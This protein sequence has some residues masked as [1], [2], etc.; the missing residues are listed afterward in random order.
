MSVVASNLTS[1]STLTSAS[2]Y[3]SSSISPVANA[4]ILVSVESLFSTGTPNTPTVTGTSMTWVQ[5]NTEFDGSHLRVTVFRSLSAAPGSGAL[6]IDFSAQAQHDV[7]IS[8]DQFTGVNTTGTNGSGAVVQSVIGTGTSTTPSV[9]LSAFASVSNYA[10]GTMGVEAGGVTVTKGA[11][12]T[13][14]TNLANGSTGSET[15]YAKNQTTVNWSM[16]SNTYAAVALE[17]AAQTTGFFTFMM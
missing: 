9:T 14:L 15:E 12:F 17:I 1:I 6:T 5:V 4:L 2:S 10:Y 8:I 7:N 16:T 13:E 11:S 3:N